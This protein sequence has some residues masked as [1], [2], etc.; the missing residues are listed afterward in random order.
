MPPPPLTVC[1]VTEAEVAVT[2]TAAPAV[3]RLAVGLVAATALLALC[4]VPLHSSTAVVAAADA[5]G[6]VTGAKTMTA[7]MPGSARPWARPLPLTVPVREPAPHRP[8]PQRPTASSNPLPGTMGLVGALLLALA[9]A[10]AA[11]ARLGKVPG[12]VQRDVLLQEVDGWTIANTAAEQDTAE[13]LVDGQPVFDDQGQR[14]P[15]KQ[16]YK[17]FQKAQQQK[18]QRKEG[19]AQA[20]ADGAAAK[21]KKAKPSSQYANTVLLPQTTFDL[22]A[23]STVRE[24]ELQAFWKRERVYERLLEG[25]RERFTLHDGPPYA[26]GSL[27]MGHALNKVLKDII[28]KYQILRGKKVEYIPGW[29][30]HGLPIELKVLQSVPAEKK[31]TLGPMELRR[32]ARDFAVATVETQK[33]AFER[34]GVWGTFDR[35]YLTLDPQYE[36]AQIRMFGKMVAGGHIYRGRKPVYW[37]PSSRTALAEAEL[38]YPEGHTSPSIYVGMTVEAAAPVLKDYA[39][40]GRLQL[41]IWTTTPWTIPANRAIS[42][43]P[44]LSY[45]VVEREGGGGRL[46]VAEA[47]VQEVQTKLGCG[48]TVLATFPGAAL[49]GTTYRHP[50]SDRRNPVVMG[51]DYITTA[52]GTG[53]VHTAPGHGNDDYLT[54]MKHGLE[55]FAPVDDAGQFTAEAGEGLE[56]LA[57]LGEGNKV[58]RQRLEEA[59]HLLHFEPYEHKYPY[60]WRTKKPCITRATKQWFCSVDGFREEA[61]R[62][63]ASVQWIPQSGEN[64]IRGMVEQRSD[65]CISRQ[66]TWGVPIPVFYEE[67]TGEE[68]LDDRVISHV[69]DIFSQRGSDAWW[70]LSAEELLPQEVLATGKKYVKGMDT[71]DVWFDSGS[72]WASVIEQRGL[73]LPVD[74]YL[75]GS[76]QSRGWFQSSLLT[77]VAVTGQAPY[78]TVLTHGFMLDE[79]GFKMSKSLG[80]VMDPLVVI[81]GG[82][83]PEKEPAYGADTL[84]L[85]VSSVNY[86]SDVMFGTNVLG[87]ISGNY[88]KIRGTIRFLLGNL[89]DFAAEKD[90]VPI[91]QLPALDQFLLQRAQAVFQSVT[92]AYDQYQFSR[93]FAELLSFCVKDLSSFYLD[94]A[95]DRLYISQ[96]GDPRRRSC[97][98]VLHAVLQG[99]LRLLAPVLCH[100]AEDAWQAMRREGDPLSVFEAGWIPAL[101]GELSVD[102][103]RWAQLQQL[104]GQVDLALEQARQASHIA[105]AL[106][107]KVTLVVPDPALRAFLARLNDSPNDVD[108][109]RYLFIVSQ[110]DITDTPPETPYQ[111][112]SDIGIAAVSRADGGK[113]ARCWNYSPAL[114][115]APD[116]PELCLRCAKILGYA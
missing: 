45:A 6:V 87:Q 26:N 102:T 14:I 39:G 68:L 93:A 54:G 24:P 36:A 66:R 2:Y 71:M 47:L 116:H 115:V 60:D 91:T 89:F 43:N 31:A 75:E 59:G 74:I 78:K 21:P 32:L 49:E 97:Q 69:A 101:S 65:W 83:N 107:A 80:N 82:K 77:S 10:M 33:A 18:A 58:V 111:A 86:S 38:E 113:C 4:V 64:R 34:F 50:L 41:A 20:K 44:S 25:D 98:T 114:G 28:N 112:S 103:D 79:K 110:V 30:T 55:V 48:L 19:K 16:A 95:K 73:P 1:L 3:G 11:T 85:W 22:R 108:N 8:T 52:A 15:S 13:F 12:V 88:R 76:D 63:I 42:V 99:M 9:T 67:A 61:L 29:D 57:V 53:L 90:A 23:N 70:E 56:G 72:S 100:L 17:K 105:A 27:H 84:R 35:P 92:E 81:G 104:R 96:A 106:E 37:S 7:T 5:T 40:D 62:A 46:V 94:I 51:G 109:L